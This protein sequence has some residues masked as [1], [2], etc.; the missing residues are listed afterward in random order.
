MS[1]VIQNTRD[2]AEVERVRHASVELANIGAVQWT[3]NWDENSTSH[4]TL[5]THSASGA[6]WVVYL[7]DH[8]W[9]GEVRVLGEVEAVSVP[10]A[11]PWEE[12]GCEACRAAWSKPGRPGLK[13]LGTNLARHAHLHRCA[14]CGAYW[15]ELERYA[16]QVSKSEANELMKGAQT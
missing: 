9:S 14:S 16:H 11:T 2:R 15:E 5:F 10:V 8:A 13:H 12:Q 4:N 7:G 1:L 6:E 3:D